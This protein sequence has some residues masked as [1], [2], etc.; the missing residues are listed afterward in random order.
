MIRRKNFTIIELL[1]VIA[2]V[3]ILASILLPSLKQARAKTKSAVCKANLKQIGIAVYMY[4]TDNSNHM[5][6]NNINSTSAFTPGMVYYTAPY[7]EIEMDSN[8][9]QTDLQGTVFDEPV[10]EGYIK[11]P[12]TS[13]YG[14]NWRYMGYKQTD[15][16]LYGRKKMAG[17]S[18]PSDS[19]IAGDTSDTRNLEGHRYFRYQNVGSRHQQKINVLH[20]DGSAVTIKSSVLGTNNNEKW[21]YGEE[22]H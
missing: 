19:M 4:T 17:A 10:L 11:N 5:P 21:W 18:S 13:G 2:I 1:V 6:T 15:H 7:L 20:L 3:G 9:L 14:W 16:S 22:A 8:P 12:V